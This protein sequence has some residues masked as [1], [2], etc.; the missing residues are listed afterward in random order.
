MNAVQ[1][2][3]PHLR[4]IT[5]PAPLRNLPYWMVW[6][7]ERRPNEVKP[8]K[9]PYY[10][11]GER[12]HGQQGTP[13]DLAKLTTF[14]LA[15]VAAVKLG[16]DGVGFAHVVEGGVVTL[17][18]DNC[19]DGG[20]VDPAVLELVRN[21]YAE[22]SPSGTGVHATF[23]GDASLLGNRKARATEGAFGVEA[24]SSTGFTTFTG[25][26]LDHV[27]LL[28][29]EDTV[30]PIPQRVLDFCQQRFGRVDTIPDTD[31]FTAGFEPRLNLS[32]SQMEKLLDALDPDMG[33]DDW[34]KVGMALHHE[35]EGDDTGFDLWNDWSSAGGK[36]PSEEGL[37]EQWD[38]FTRRMG[39]G[40]KQ[41]TMATT[42]RL[43]KAAGL[44]WPPAPTAEDV[45]A[46]ADAIV[47]PAE[48]AVK[49]RTPEGYSGRFKA[50]SPLDVM[51]QPPTQWLIRHVVPA[52]DLIV[53]YGA[54]GAGKSF[55]ALDMA[56]HIARGAPWR[57][58]RTEKG[59]VVYV[60]AEGGGGVGKRFRAYCDYHGIDATTLDVATITAAPNFLDTDDI[61]EMTAT[62]RA[63][64]DVSLLI[65]DTFA[66]VTPGANENAG[67]DMGRALRNARLLREATGATV[68]LVH[69]A[70]KDLSRGAR[71]WSGIKAA[72]DAEIEV[73]RHEDGRGREIAL[74]KM[75]DGEDGLRWGFKLE[76]ILLGLDDYGDEITS[77]VAVEA[78][79]AKTAAEDKERKGVR[80]R[81][82]VEHHV[83]EII[84]TMGEADTCSLDDLIRQSVESMPVE[85]GQRDTR[86][87]VVVRAIQKMAKEQDGPLT[88]AGG[89][90]IFY[91]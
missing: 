30:A 56:I 71:G 77:C 86:R 2:I 17:D 13:I 78:E 84:A 52:A 32:V 62:L 54:S 12:R 39:P 31:D 46:K 91:A 1:R 37:R 21:T 87:Q 43:A 16:M 67:E 11:T 80:R 55:V 50:V 79:L 48:A 18:F 53:L 75:K 51:S 14:A 15:R 25:H 36:Y 38:S 10:P 23:V 45:A 35:C 59:R 33:R 88:I 5:A 69:H 49:P 76:T 63:L 57:G 61:T 29:L 64:G 73:V 19:V 70:G 44:Q 34:I 82:R 6:R 65:V 66:Q 41:V 47:G 20:T 72:A 60:A 24:F 4:T 22:F 3:T 74:G 85:A 26:L 83:L 58:K 9:V 28:G 68:M 7:L 90:V 40:R 27:D 81:G 8:R 89:R 42:I